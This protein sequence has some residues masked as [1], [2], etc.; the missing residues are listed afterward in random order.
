MNIG[1]GKALAELTLNAYA[2]IN[3]CLD[4]TGRR[5][6]GYHLVK[7]VMQTI[8][9]HDTLIFRKGTEPGIKLIMDAGDLPAGPDNLIIKGINAA[10]AA[11]AEKGNGRRS[12]MP[13]EIELKKR[14]PIAAGMAGGSTDAAAAMTGVNRLAGLGLTYEELRKAAVHVGA[15]VPYCLMGGTALAEGIGE[16]LTPLTDI[17]ECCVAVARPDAHVSTAYVYGRLDSMADIVH[18][19]TDAVLER[20][21]AR[22]VAGMAGYMGNVLERVT[23]TEHPVITEIKKTMDG[24]GALKAMMSGSGPSVFGIFGS[25][26]EAEAACASIR[27]RGLTNVTFVTRTVGRGKGET[28]YA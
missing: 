26:E 18:P 8:D 25:R 14:I 15:D 5:G 2:K 12:S 4:V 24:Y 17:G 11:A 10:E 27:E 6:D 23:E 3:L 28:V 20:I 1:G 9:L 13:L 7:M 22:D 19:D 21:A 16:V